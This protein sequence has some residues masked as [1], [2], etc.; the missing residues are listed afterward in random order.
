[1]FWVYK[2]SETVCEVGAD[3]GGWV[4]EDLSLSV[5]MGLMILLLS[6]SGE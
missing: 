1:M 4:E 3:G 6:S 2:D 5:P